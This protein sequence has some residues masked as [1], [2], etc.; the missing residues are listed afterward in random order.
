[1]SIAKRP[2]TIKE[3]KAA[4]AAYRDSQPVQ[5]FEDADLSKLP[6]TLTFTQYTALCEMTG[7]KSLSAS[8][9]KI[10]MKEVTKRLSQSPV[11]S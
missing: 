11:Q 10:I 2:T 4:L 3:L 7:T 8:Q 1:M 5:I 6:D 9:I